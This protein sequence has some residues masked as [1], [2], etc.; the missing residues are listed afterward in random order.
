MTSESRDKLEALLRRVEAGEWDSL[1]P[2]QMAALEAYLNT[3]WHGQ[4]AAPF[5]R[6]T[7]ESA[8]P[9]LAIPDSD[10]PTPAEWDRVWNNIEAGVT[11]GASTDSADAAGVESIKLPRQSRAQ[12]S[13]ARRLIRFWPVFT[14]AAACIGLLFTWQFVTPPPASTGWAIQLADEV[15]VDE[16]DVYGDTTAFVDF[17]DDGTAMIWVFEDGVGT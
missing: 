2:E 6:A 15:E 8:L 10:M 14:A 17:N 16:L 13:V 4:T 9:N 3:G 1:T 5:D 7:G 11:S 12:R